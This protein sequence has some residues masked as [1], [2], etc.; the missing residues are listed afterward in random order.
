MPRFSQRLR[1]VV[2][3]AFLLAVAPPA[4]QWF[5]SLAN[6]SAIFDG[7]EAPAVLSGLLASLPWSTSAIVFVGGIVIGVWTDW[8]SRTFDD[9]WRNAGK[10]LGAQLSQLGDEL[11]RLQ[12]AAAR[13]SDWPKNLG[14]AR[15]GVTRALVRMRKFGIWNPGTAAFQIPRGGEFLV[16]FFREIGTLLQSERFEEAKTRAR[17]AQLRFELI[18]HSP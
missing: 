8:W 6:G 5:V 1:I 14:T 18:G 9:N 15:L 12:F 16:D 11:A 10:R 3:I 13:A 4:A 7:G 2:S 17:A